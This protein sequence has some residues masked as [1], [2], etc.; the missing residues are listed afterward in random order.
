MLTGIM[1]TLYKEKIQVQVRPELT[2]KPSQYGDLEELLSLSSQIEGVLPCID[3]SHLFARNNGANNSAQE[4]EQNL[5]RYAQVLGKASLSD[6]HLHVS[7]IEFTP[8][9]ERKHLMLKESKFRYRELLKVL[10][11]MKAG[12]VVIC[13][14][15]S[16]EDDARLLQSSYRRI[17]T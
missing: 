8:K 7:G 15:P 17:K 6:L 3:F 11:K 13:E 16:P 9:G 10:K 5:L 1:E 12:G 2:G 4:H 14:S